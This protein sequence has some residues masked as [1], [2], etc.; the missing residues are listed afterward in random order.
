VQVVEQT[1][2]RA[3]SDFLVER[4]YSVVDVLD[5]AKAGISN[6]I[7]I[8]GGDFSNAAIGIGRT[9]QGNG[10]ARRRD[11]KSKKVGKS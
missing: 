7:T 1:L 10:G 11:E 4:G 6:S 5:V 2:F 8:K 9:S 3:V